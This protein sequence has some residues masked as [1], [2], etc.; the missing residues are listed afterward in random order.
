[1]KVEV[2]AAQRGPQGELQTVITS[3]MACGQACRIGR[4]SPG[5]E[6]PADEERSTTHTRCGWENFDP[7][8]TID[9]NCG[10]N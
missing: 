2:A 9:L 7:A 8:A 6:P 3:G 1:M 4:L 5:R 10:D